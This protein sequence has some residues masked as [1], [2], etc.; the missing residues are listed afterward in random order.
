[1]TPSTSW[2]E[3][4][5]QSFCQ[6]QSKLE[7]DT[8]FVACWPAVWEGAEGYRRSSLAVEEKEST[9]LSKA[10]GCQ[11]T[12]WTSFYGLQLISKYLV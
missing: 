3:Y 1:M 12:I 11:G 7:G 8:W 4:T 5:Y 10:H 2:S 9:G 6:T